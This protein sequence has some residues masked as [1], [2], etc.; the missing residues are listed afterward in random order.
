M[1]HI[2]CCINRQE[3][4]YLLELKRKKIGRSKLD[5]EIFYKFEEAE[6]WELQLDIINYFVAQ[7]LE[8][9][10]KV[11][12]KLELV[13]LIYRLHS[14]NELWIEI[15]EFDFNFIDYLMSHIRDKALNLEENIIDLKDKYTNHD[16]RQIIRN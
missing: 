6:N 7:L 14:N 5:A 12:T 1:S 11:E 13:E 16:Y 4:Y 10:H 2:T 3:L 15:E 9:K 8:R